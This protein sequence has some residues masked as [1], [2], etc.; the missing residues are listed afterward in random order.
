[1]WNWAMNIQFKYSSQTNMK[2]R[3]AILTMLFFCFVWLAS[4][5]KTQVVKLVTEYRENPIGIDVEKPRL[6]WQ[7][8]S[9]ENNVT[10]T[11]YEIRVAA[12]PKELGKKDALLW[13]SGKVE[14]HRSVHVEYG[15]TPLK[16]MQRA[17]WQV[18]I[19]DN[20]GRV[21]RWSR[22]AY[23]ETAL[24]DNNEWQASWITMK[25][26][27]SGKSLPAQ[28]YRSEFTCSKEIKSARVY[29]T[30]LG[31][32]Q[33]FMNGEKVGEQ[34]FTPGF[35]SYKKRLQYQT[36]DV[37]TMLQKENAIGAMVGDG[38]YRG[39][40]GWQGK[41]AYYGDRLAFLAQLQINY[42]DGSSETIISDENWLTSYGAILQSDIY[43]GEKYDARKEMPGWDKSG[44]DAGAWKNVK[45]LNHSKEILVAANG[46]PVRAIEEIK[47]VE[48]LTTPKGETVVDLGQNMVGYVRLKVDGKRGDEVKLQFAEVLDKNGNFYTKNLRT[49]K[50]TDI[51]TLKG[52]GEEIY[53]PYFTFHGFRYVKLEGYP[54]KFGKDAITGIVI[55][56]DMELTGRFSCSDTLINRLQSN[57]QWGQRG[58][59]LDIP[60]DCPQRDER[61]GWTGD[62]QVFCATA[63]F[64]FNVAVFFTKWLKD[65]TLDQQPDGEVPNIVPDMWNN[66]FG[67]CAGWADAAVIVPWTLYCAYGDTRILEQQY[68]GMKKWIAYM[69]KHAGEDYLWNEKRHQWGDWLSFNSNK[70]GYP[71]AYTE[72]DLIATAYFCYS[73]SLMEKIAH[74]LHKNKD[75]EEFGTLVKSIK[76]AFQ[77]EYITA[78]GRLVSHTQTAYALALSF[79]L[80]PENLRPKAA[81][82][83]AADVK[84]FG[85]LT[86]GF[87]G[88]PLLCSTLSSI[89]RDD[90]A[91]M[92]LNRKQFP[93]WLYPVTKGATTIWERWDTMK[94]DG[95]I[96][97]GMNSFNHYAY[98]AIGEWLYSHV[99]GLKTCPE[100]PGYKHIV[101][102]PHPGG[103][104]SSASAALL[105]MYGQVKSAWKL[106]NEK[107][108]YEINIPPNTTASVTLPKAKGKTVL[109]NA[110]ELKLD[111]N[112]WGD[113]LIIKIG[114]G[115][116]IFEY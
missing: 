41:K 88:T 33:L 115:H 112:E 65:L 106:G 12:S 49:A 42:V 99:A 40:L 74:I 97:E 56:S 14:S 60:T 31:L 38:W 47:P 116:Y 34:L 94:P 18:R 59:F 43:N 69:E 2:K 91:F 72:T 98:G 9:E 79:D 105:S 111:T 19:W 35:T 4:A 15:G 48:I 78:N 82:Y 63:A 51:Y 70:A 10:Q 50:A 5:A 113:D 83:L 36:Y 86:T 24:L 16:S 68:A 77:K 37:T 32:Y 55:H 110:E 108:I 17:Y 107:F 29:V 87:L 71:G 103:G 58:N 45:T 96:I 85:H 104:L 114:S 95:S 39:Y 92:L 26:E 13:S 21:S 73:T 44:F 7:I 81:A 46:M 3:K 76:T 67:G 75:A 89:E 80:V 64:N 84:K 100:N 66:K 6:S 27:E 57:I 23:W 1:M 28:Y 52:G 20:K 102:H 54:G 11:A 25:E 101:F 8:S 61:V 30:S 62:A 53:E 90:L 22:P 109:M 93:G